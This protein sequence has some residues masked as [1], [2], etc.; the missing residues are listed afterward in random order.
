MLPGVEVRARQGRLAALFLTYLKPHPKM[1]TTYSRVRFGA[2][3]LY[4]CTAS[5]SIFAQSTGGTP[6]SAPEEVIELTPFVVNAGNDNDGYRVGKSVTGS[7]IA[8]A[9]DELPLTISIVNREQFSDANLRTLSDISRYLPGVSL[10]DRNNLDAERFVARGFTVGAVLRNGVDFNTLSD[11]S[12]IERVELARGP[13]AVLYGV[14]EP[15]GVMNYATKRPLPFYRAEAKFT[16]GSYDLKR[17]EFDFNAPLSADKKLLLRIAGSYTD[18]EDFRKYERNHMLF[19]NPTLS[20]Q[21]F[22]NTK[23]TLDMTK[24]DS[25]GSNGTGIMNYVL[26]FSKRYNGTLILN[27]PNMGY[28]D[29]TTGPNEFRRDES[30]YSELRLEQVF[31]DNLSMQVIAAKGKS[32]FENFSVYM[33]T[34]RVAGAEAIEIPAIDQLETSVF[35]FYEEA[36]RRNE[37]F[38]VNMLGNFNIG[39]TRHNIVLGMQATRSPATKDNF[40][41]APGAPF[42]VK[43]TDSDAV[44]YG[45]LTYDKRNTF[46]QWFGNPVPFVGSFGVPSYFITD[47]ISVFEERLHVLAGARY[48]QYSDLGGD[49]KVLPQLGAIY[50]LRDGVSVYATY[51]STEKSNGRRVQDNAPRPLEEAT[52]VDVGIKFSSKNG[53]ISGSLA[54]YMIKKKN[55]A[56]ADFSNFIDIRNGTVINLDS[57]LIAGEAES[58][59]IEA[60]LYY[61]PS[62]NFQLVAGYAHTDAEV[63]RDIPERQ[64]SQLPGAIKDSVTVFMKYTFADGALAGLEVGGG[65]VYNFGPVRYFAPTDFFYGVYQK[66]DYENIDLFAKYSFKFSGHQATVTLNVNNATDSRYISNSLQASTP[67]T[68]AISLGLRY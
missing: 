9:L 21:P 63:T 18:R 46:V 6:P 59:G 36:I 20:W 57:V 64:G 30:H 37:H 4:V 42:V 8:T 58:K 61:Q 40:M 31:N 54:G 66:K 44:R 51:S 33:N 24:K 38:E 25:R 28:D 34:M 12:N 49:P 50:K 19:F 55:L 7:R 15:G 29:S 22:K 2:L 14:L 10:K 32:Y 23:I 65:G 53:K 35:P 67:I 62:K 48:Q 17:T 52:G 1:S 5:S 47:Q 27:Y 39:S 68:A 16:Y 45:S 60:E 3:L 26:D 11:A 13:A 41:L 56:I 43:L